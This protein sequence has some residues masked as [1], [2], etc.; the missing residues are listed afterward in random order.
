MIRLA[1]LLLAGAVMNQTLQPHESHIPFHLQFMMDHNLYGMNHIHVSAVKFRV[2][3]SFGILHHIIIHIVVV[4]IE[5]H[6]VSR[7]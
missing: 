4:N 1:E 2:S 5:F 7:K 6:T 3:G